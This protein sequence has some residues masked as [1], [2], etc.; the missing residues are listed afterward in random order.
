[1]HRQNRS[2]STALTY[3]AKALKAKLKRKA[4]HR[5]PW[6]SR[7]MV[8][9]ETIEL[10]VVFAMVVISIIVMMLMQRFTGGV[11]NEE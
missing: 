8:V 3:G 11:D 10:F 4:A 1:M 7:P 2:G 6:R 9:G 5:N